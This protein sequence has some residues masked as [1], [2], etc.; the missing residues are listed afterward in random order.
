MRVVVI[1][2]GLGGCATA[3]RLAKLGHRVVLLERAAAPG[4]ALG[5][6]RQGDHTWDAGPGT[7]LLPAVLRDLFRKSGRPLERELELVPVEVIR[8]HRFRDGGSLRLTG[9]SRAA[10]KAAF[11][12]L[13]PGLGAR[14]TAYV[15]ALGR[16]WELLRRDYLERPWDPGLADRKTVGL[17]RRRESLDRRL[18]RTLGDERLRLVAAHPLAVDGHDPRR[19]PAWAGTVSYVEQKFGAWRVAD[20]T[21]A[22]GEALARRLA[23]R[24]VEVLTGTTAHDVVLRGGRAVAVASSVGELD[25]DAVVCAVDPRTLPVLRR[26]VRR[27]R[28]A[29]L[30]T[31]HHLGLVEPPPLAHDLVLHAG[32]SDPLAVVRPWGTAPE[33]AASWT[34]QLRGAPG[35]DVL[36]RLADRGL[37]VRDRVV[38]HVVR[39]PGTLR[40]EWGGSPLGV[41]W[42]GRATVRRRLG[43][44]TPVPGVYAAGAH[45]TPGSGIPF[46]GL[47]AALVAQAL[48]PA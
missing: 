12:A 30:P 18:R 17:L 32:H 35:Q 43:P 3:A 47:S 41:Q 21:A 13:G 46:V 14:W 27:T 16:E 40:R 8:E 33:G 48:G 7:T 37:D 45:A 23:T 28:P 10:Q 26:H 38:E 11:E 19:V 5:V 15:D 24:K 22:L 1:G 20:G 42:Q 9:G 4:G 25:A 2:G 34:V 29:P 44:T 31:L 39:D 36:A 6:V